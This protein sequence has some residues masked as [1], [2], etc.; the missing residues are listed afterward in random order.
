MIR[1]TLTRN[2]TVSALVWAL[3]SGPG[4][5]AAFLGSAGSVCRS[6]Y[7]AQG[8][9]WMP[10]ALR[11]RASN[12]AWLRGRTGARPGY[13]RWRRMVAQLAGAIGTARYVVVHESGDFA[14]PWE[15]EMWA[16]VATLC[17]STRFWVRTRT[18]RLDGEWVQA[19]RRLH[20]A[21][22][23]TVRLSALEVDGPAPRVVAG[24][25]FAYEFPASRVV[26]TD[27]PGCP[28]QEHGSCSRAGCRA[29]WDRSVPVVTYRLHSDPIV[30]RKGGIVDWQS[31]GKAQTRAA[32]EV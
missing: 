11:V 5:C 10:G 29:C 7:A 19:L 31:F 18:W 26:A 14:Q 2:G 15:T 32:M 16:D 8:T 1:P 20:Q 22:N 17:P 23:V 6:C 30:A 24:I 21:P 4:H 3:P 25:R 13:R 27:G 12:A 9:H 28:K